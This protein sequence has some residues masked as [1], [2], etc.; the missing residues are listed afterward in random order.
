MTKSD[1]TLQVAQRIGI[2]RRAANRI[3]TTIFD[4]IT[5]AMERQEKVQIVGFGSFEVRKRA[6]RFAKDPRT[7]VEIRIPETK[8]V[9]FRAGTP[10]RNK[11]AEER[12][13]SV[14]R[15]YSQT[16]DRDVT[17]SA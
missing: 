3:T 13:D 14:Q 12:R 15:A 4:V 16:S 11:V 7:G 5:E 6:A 8:T 17:A 10:L 1:L 9:G 2:S